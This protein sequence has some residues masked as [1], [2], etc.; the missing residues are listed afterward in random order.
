MVIAVPW[1]SPGLAA[2]GEPR[3]RLHWSWSRGDGPCPTRRM[4]GTWMCRS[5]FLPARAHPRWKRGTCS[6]QDRTNFSCCIVLCPARS[7]HIFGPILTV[8]I[9]GVKYRETAILHKNAEKEKNR[10]FF[11][12]WLEL[13]G[14]KSLRDLKTYQMSS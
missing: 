11:W 9:S 3:R 4:R 1:G 7:Q 10:V 6:L 8:V 13:H 14:A 2:G 5:D 12:L